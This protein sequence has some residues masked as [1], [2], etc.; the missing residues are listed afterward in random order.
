MLVLQLIVSVLG[1]RLG[2]KQHLLCQ[3][4]APFLHL[5]SAFI[6]SACFIPGVP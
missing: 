2:R 4:S 6:A 1:E 5:Y 3:Y